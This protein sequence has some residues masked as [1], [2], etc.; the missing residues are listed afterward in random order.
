MV[1]QKRA[2]MPPLQRLAVGFLGVV[3]L[4]AVGVLLLSIARVRV[5]ITPRAEPVA[6]DF[7]L[8]VIGSGKPSDREVLGRLVRVDGTGSSGEQAIGVATGA[9]ALSDAASPSVP[10][11][12]E[13]TP[14]RA[15]GTVTLINRMA[16]PQPLV[17]TTRLLALD[18]TLFRM[19]SG[20]TIPASGNV[21][22]VRVAADQP[23]SSGNIGPTKF[24]IP[25]LSKWLQARV[26]AESSTAMSGGRGSMLAPQAGSV[27]TPRAVVTA[28][29][30]AAARSKAIDAATADA[31]ARA[32]A[33]AK[34][35]EEVI[36]MET[37]APQ[38]T[39]RGALGEVRDSVRAD[40]TVRLTA[41][42]IPKGALSASGRVALEAV[43][44]SSGRALLRMRSD[45]LT[46]RLIAQDPATARATIAV[47]AE[48]DAA[49]R[50]GSFAFEPRRISGFTGEEVQTY[51]RSLPGVQDVDVELRPFWVKRVPA[52]VGSVNVEVRGAE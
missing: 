34:D 46:T 18:G 28:A 50:Q 36:R 33:L 25:G 39:V 3:V 38:V 43:A 9:A 48:G 11:P 10:A 37:G 2:P 31:H 5:T 24:T 12:R 17:A 32:A 51:L 27:T 16:S 30:V 7:D 26:W 22:N 45:A 49:I 21:E 4:L 13:D 29:D 19:K 20:V 6:V 42:L 35:G 41:L 52:N 1:K 14:A 40:A 8:T 15:E 47:H 23:G 44:A